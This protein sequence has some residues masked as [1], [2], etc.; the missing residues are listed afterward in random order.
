MKITS[1]ESCESLNSENPD[2][3]KK[4]Q[5]EM[6]P[7][8]LLSAR[9][10]TILQECKLLSARAET[11]LQECKLI[12]A[13]AETDLSFDCYLRCRNGN[14]KDERKDERRK[15]IHYGFEVNR[16]VNHILPVQ[17]GSFCR[18]AGSSSQSKSLDI[19]PL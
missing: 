10:E 16:F 19:Q 15:S 9:A 5:I 6:H 7:C 13:R 14:V 12:S 17:V 11:I 4:R 8:K 2:S 3:D 18:R 1:A